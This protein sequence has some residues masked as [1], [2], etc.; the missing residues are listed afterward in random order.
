VDY[1]NRV[2]YT[3]IVV[4]I[5]FL[6]GIGLYL[7]K[8]A[9]ASIEHYFLGGRQLPWW[10][11]GVSGMASFLDVAGTM[12][13]VSFLYM[14]GPRGLFV[15]FRGGAVLVLIFMLL[16]TGKWHRRSGCMTGAEWNIYRFGSGVGGQFARFVQ[17]VAQTVFAAFMIAYMVK[18][19]GPFLATFLP[20]TPNTC[21]LFLVTVA[22]IYTMASGF[23]G[24]VFTDFVQSLIILI[25]VIGISAT[26]VIELNGYDQPLSELAAKVTGSTQWMTSL[27]HAHTEMPK[28]YEQYSALMMFALFALFRNVLGGLG[29]G[30]DPK[31]FGA[32]SDRECGLL[33]FLWTWLMMFRWP[34]MMGFA[35]LGLFLVNDLFPDQAVLDETATLIKEHYPDVADNEWQ[36]KLAGISPDTEPELVAQLTRLMGDKWPQKL[37]LLSYEGTVNPEQILPSVLLF[38]IPAGF[39]GL[40][41]IA[42][43]AAS[44]STFDSTV[45]MTVGFFTRDVYQAYLKPDANNRQLIIATYI[46]GVILVAAGVGLGYFIKNINHIWGWIIMSLTA[47][48]AVKDMIKFYWWRFNAGGVVIGT[49]VGMGTA[50]IQRVIWPDSDEKLT[51]A[52]VTTITLASA[53]IGTYL[54]PPTNA[55]VLEHFYKTTRPF[56]FWGPFKQTLDSRIRQSMR[57]EHFYDVVSL[58]FV[59]G[60]QVTLFLLPM[61]FVIQ[62]WTSFYITLA[63][64]LFCLLM[65]YFLWYRNLPPKDAPNYPGPTIDPTSAER[66]P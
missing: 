61:Q 3:V 25:A 24:V 6:V 22:T 13:I 42:L 36:E 44:M 59:F 18:G 64:F 51:F 50:I 7:R 1:L 2:D 20:F 45:N 28:G 48:L 9:S 17:V 11:L 34:M 29:S 23:Y 55:A 27:P 47:A 63:F 66:G 14:L 30:G 49:I 35:V 46:Y 58:P 54:T 57:R 43:I 37:K 56:G 5:L 26:A 19:V 52:V 15:E 38:K 10:A 39:R 31:Y 8:K 12:L 60:W 32:R 40:L 4:Y 62:A 21:A 33:T 41:L 65:M 16:W 53:I